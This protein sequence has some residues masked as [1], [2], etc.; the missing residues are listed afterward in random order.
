MEAAAE[1][2]ARQARQAL[3]DGADADAAASTG[4]SHSSHEPSKAALLLRVW[5]EGVLPVERATYEAELARAL[6]QEGAAASPAELAALR[7]TVAGVANGLS[8][9]EA[10]DLAV[11]MGNKRGPGG[12]RGSSRSGSG[13]GSGSAIASHRRGSKVSEG[14]QSSFLGGLGLSVAGESALERGSLDSASATGALDDEDTQG[15]GQGQRQSTSVAE[16]EARKAALLAAGVQDPEPIVQVR[17]QKAAAGH[18]PGNKRVTDPSGSGVD[19]TALPPLVHWRL[20]ERVRGGMERA[21][22]LGLGIGVGGIRRRGIGQGGGTVSSA[23][24][25][26]SSASASAS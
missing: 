10:V 2:A 18:R 8:V 21:A 26:A 12:R 6:E 24:S 3:E 17:E 11:G 20:L 23:A 4:G 13:S 19:L 22:A 15:Q 7:R 9:R 16:D 1:G 25:V 14:G 5:D